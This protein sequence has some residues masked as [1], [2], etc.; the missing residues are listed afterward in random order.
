MRRT[1]ATFVSGEASVTVPALGVP[2]AA[3]ARLHGWRA[4]DAA[5]SL[6]ALARRLAPHRPGAHAG[7]ADPRRRPGRCRCASARHGSPPPSPPTC[8]TRR[9]HPSG[10]PRGDGPRP[11]HAAGTLPIARHGPWELAALELDEPT[12]L[13]ATNGHQNGENVA[14]GTQASG[15]VT[16]GTVSILDA[17][18]RAIASVSPAAWR[19]A[20]AASGARAAGGGVG[21]AFTDSGLPGIVRPA[22]PSDTRRC[23]CSWIPPP[24]PPPVR[25]A[26]SRSRSTA[27]RWPR[28]SPAS[29]ARFP[30]VPPG[31]AGFVVAD[32]QTLAGALDAQLPGQGRA[33]ELWISSHD[34]APLRAA[35]DGRAPVEP[36]GPVPADD[37]T[38]AARRARRARRARHAD[39]RR[40]AVGRAG[41]P[42]AARGAAGT[43]ARRADGERPR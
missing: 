21:V 5:A 11:R 34:L 23:R 28:A 38:R 40:G 14:A 17:A 26:G 4:S 15:A 24:R 43:G 10:E 30:T 2:A 41:D 35:L 25:A 36:A 42:R 19:G 7:R 13:E 18:G 1:Q 22:Q 39:R 29:S 6:P 27:S 31:S 8:V 20:G 3:L 12:G 32:E 9:H 33:D 37:R 16:L